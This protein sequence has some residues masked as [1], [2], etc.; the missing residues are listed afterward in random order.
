[1]SQIIEILNMVKIIG[2]RIET[3]EA[4]FH[5]IESQIP[6]RQLV[7][8]FIELARNLAIPQADIQ[9]L[10]KLAFDIS[11][12]LLKEYQEIQDHKE[13]V[14]DEDDQKL[15]QLVNQIIPSKQLSQ[16]FMLQKLALYISPEIIRQIPELMLKTFDADSDQSLKHLAIEIPLTHL[17]HHQTFLDLVK[18]TS[19]ESL[20]QLKKAIKQF[21]PQHIYHIYE[22]NLLGIKLLSDLGQLRQMIDRIPFTKL[23]TLSILQQFADQLTPAD[24]Q[25]LNL[26]VEK[27]PRTPSLQEINS[28]QGQLFKSLFFFLYFYNNVYF[29]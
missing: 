28:E 3:I 25:Q 6:K 18:E 8:Q 15:D 4:Y 1:M 12:K 23:K 22:K 14:S 16:I 21:P 19:P 17:Q 26:F 24:F 2:S 11:P 9:E 27:I 10:Q 7:Q 5:S 20:Q 13:L 29:K